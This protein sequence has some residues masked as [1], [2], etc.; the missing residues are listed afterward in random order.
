MSQTPFNLI[1]PGELNNADLRPDQIVFVNC[2]GYIQASGLRKLTAFVVD[3]GFLFTTDWALKHVLEKAF[4]GYVKFN[5]KATA[6]EVVRVEVLDNKDPFLKSI[7]G[8]EDDPQWWL[9]GSSYPI[10]V[11]DEE[12]V[13]ILVTSQDIKRRYG[14]APVFITFDHGEG[15]IYHMISHFYLQRS[16]TRTARHS[17]SAEMYMVEKES[18][19]ALKAKYKAMGIADY[20][21]VDVE[22]AFTSSAMMRKMIY[23]KKRQMRERGKNET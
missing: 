3:G 1:D 15:K 7:L 4:P 8:P 21:I 16:E 23:D 22:G 11:L 19:D 5:E 2:P 18:P 6:D 9:E 20:N 14:E 13:N 10:R 17:A 12:N